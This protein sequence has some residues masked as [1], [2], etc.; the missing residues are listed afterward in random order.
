M[1]FSA[2][3]AD[4]NNQITALKKPID[5]LG[6]ENAALRQENTRLRYENDSLKERLGLN[7]TNSSLPPSHDLYLNKRHKRPRRNKKPGPQPGHKCQ[8]YQQHQL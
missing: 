8:S 4:L 7:S 1:N 5:C 2:V 3:I 6:Q